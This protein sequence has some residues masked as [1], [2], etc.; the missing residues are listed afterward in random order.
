MHQTLRCC[1]WGSGSRSSSHG[2]CWAAT[3]SWGFLPVEPQEENRSTHWGAQTT[4]T[5]QLTSIKALALDKVKKF[6]A[7]NMSNLMFLFFFFFL[8]YRQKQICT[9]G[10]TVTAYSNQLMFLHLP[11]VFFKSAESV[12]VVLYSRF[13]RRAVQTVWLPSSV[14]QCKTES[15]AVISRAYLFSADNNVP[16]Y[17]TCTS[18]LLCMWATHTMALLTNGH[19]VYINATTDNDNQQSGQGCCPEA[20][21]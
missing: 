15:L 9:A 6:Y 19:T 16:R 1:V 11:I 7:L 13:C 18:Q 3:D 2:L 21:P 8:R 4:Q 17:C 5:Y 10:T 14:Y 12:E 20:P